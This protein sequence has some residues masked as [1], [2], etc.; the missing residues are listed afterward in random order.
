MLTGLPRFAR[1]DTFAATLNT[2]RPS[3]FVDAVYSGGYR[4]RQS[5]PGTIANPPPEVP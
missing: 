4:C 1:N 3:P 5:T 2:Y